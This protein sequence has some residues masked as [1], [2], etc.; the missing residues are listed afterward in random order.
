MTDDD[1]DEKIEYLF[2][3]V[4]QRQKR[5]RLIILRDPRHLAHLLSHPEASLLSQHGA[6]RHARGSRCVDDAGGVIRPGLFEQIGEK[7]RILRVGFSPQ[8]QQILEAHQHG[9]LKMLQALHV[10]DD[11]LSQGRRLIPERQRLVE[12][13]LILAQINDR[14]RMPDD[15]LA[16]LGGAGRIDADIDGPGAHGPECAVQPLR[17]VLAD[18][19]D[20]IPPAH[21]EGMEAKGHPLHFLQVFGPG[22][23]P[24][25]PQALPSHGG[26]PGLLLCPV[27]EGLGQRIDWRHRPHPQ[28]NRTFLRYRLYPLT[29]VSVAMPR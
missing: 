6:L 26:A 27:Q 24:P 1:V 23:V 28:R 2:E 8:F 29:E 18:D 4:I 22:D 21:A 25:D 20:V 13:L 14:P 17:L 3:D 12:L 5:D 7:P 16:F 19:G 15:V 11:H 10:P 9:V